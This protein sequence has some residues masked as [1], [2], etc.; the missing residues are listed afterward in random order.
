FPSTRE[1]A[2]ALRNLGQSALT[3]AAGSPQQQLETAAFLDTPRPPV[4]PPLAPSLAVLPFRNM[5]SDPENEFFSEGLAEE[6]INALTKVEGLQVA[7]RTSAFAFQGKSED[8]RTI[9]EKLNV[10]A[11]LEGS[12]R[13]A[14]NRLRIS[15]QLVNAPDGSHSWSET[16]NR[17]LTDI[18]AIQDEIAHNIAAALK[19]ILSKK[20]KRAIQKVPTADVNAYEHYLRGRQYFHQF[21]RQGF[22]FAQQMFARAIA[23]DPG[24]ALA[25][26]GIADCHSLLFM[27]WDT[28]PA[29]LQ[30]ADEASRRALELDP[31][32]A[33]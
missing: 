8:V 26:A 20:E 14:G 2:L 21:R 1:L 19:V 12:V 31:G 30:Q 27:Y 33:E 11:V 16:Y 3:G 15:A 5:S 6:L 17:E 32:L 24:Y 22:E 4:A 13:K 28:S 25:H 29:N 7:S 23:A 18:F 10:R 9:A